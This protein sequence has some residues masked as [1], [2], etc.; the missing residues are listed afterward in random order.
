V[1]VVNGLAAIGLLLGVLALNAYTNA[2]APLDH[3]KIYAQWGWLQVTGNTA[4][5]AALGFGLYCVF[6]WS[7][8]LSYRDKPAFELVLG[9]PTMLMLMGAGALF[10]TL[11]N[12]LMAWAPRYAVLTYNESLSTVGLRFGFF[13]AV[14]GLIGTAMGGW[15]GDRL[16]RAT[17][18]GRLYL[19]ALAMTLPWPLVWLT[20]EQPTLTRFLAAFCLL[21]VVTTA[22]L[23]GMLSTIQDLVLP[24][25]RGLVYAV[26][27][28]MYTIIGLGTGPYIA[29]LIS[30]VTGELGK[31]IMG[32]YHATPLI[33]VLRWL[34]IRGVDGAERSRLQ[35]ARDA[36]EDIALE[37]ATI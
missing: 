6:S 37:P 3:S 12:G 27:V 9:T 26:F 17:P 24:R 22:W 33:A 18:R 35:R 34:A 30:D 14:A 4:Q 36:G 29:G 31:G 28:L 7:Q 19:S 23:P 20:L 8:S 10:M 1:W 32:L 11:T 21:S 2:L 13:A 5:W 25:M 15:L 16:R